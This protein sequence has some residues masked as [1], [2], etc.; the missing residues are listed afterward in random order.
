MAIFRGLA[1][2]LILAVAPA[3]TAAAVIGLFKDG[4]S[5][6]LAG[7]RKTLEAEGFDTRELTMLVLQSSPAPD[8]SRRKP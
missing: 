4:H 7:I 8:A 6:E 2:M 5:G 3:A 1:A